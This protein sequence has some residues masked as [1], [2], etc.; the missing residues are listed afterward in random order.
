MW[1][2]NT[3][4]EPST[5]I[6]QPLG[7]GGYQT[8]KQSVAPGSLLTVPLGYDPAVGGYFIEASQP[9]SVAWS[10]EAEK[11]IMFVAGTVVGG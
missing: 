3:G 6:L 11:G 2:L 7:L 10:V 8:T 1:L 4:S 5:V 9:I